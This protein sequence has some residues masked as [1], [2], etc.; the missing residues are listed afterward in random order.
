MEYKPL[1]RSPQYDLV[2]DD[3]S[4]PVPVDATPGEAAVIIASFIA[5]NPP[6]KLAAEVA[7]WNQILRDFAEGKLI[8]AETF[9]D[10]LKR[11]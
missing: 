7:E 8:S 9:L 4:I 6:E 2:P 11:S 10:Q 3:V 1:R 5:E